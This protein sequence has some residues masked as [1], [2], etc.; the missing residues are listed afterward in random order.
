MHVCVYTHAY[1][2][3]T[4]LNTY[5]RTSFSLNVSISSWYCCS[6][7]PNSLVLQCSYNHIHMAVSAD[8]FLSASSASSLL[9]ANFSWLTSNIGSI[10][11]GHPNSSLFNLKS[12]STEFCRVLWPNPHSACM[13]HTCMHNDTQTCIH[14]INTMCT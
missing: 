10:L 2:Q 9:L 5:V 11:A 14:T 6:K 8:L 12:S 13:G 4:G 7:S 3:K 1:C